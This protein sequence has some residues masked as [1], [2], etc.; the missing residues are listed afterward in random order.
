MRTLL[1][2]FALAAAALAGGCAH[3]PRPADADAALFHDAAFGRPTERVSTDDVFALDDAMRHYLRVEIAGALHA[4]GVQTGFVE[5]LSRKQ[6]LRLEYDSARTKTAAEAFDSRS[7]NCLSLVLMTAALAKELGLPFHYG[8]AV[9]PDLWSR[10][11]DLLFASGHINITIGRRLVDARSRFDLAPLT[12]DFLPPEEVRRLYTREI[13][14][15]TVLAMYANNR[16]AEALAGQRLADAY[17]WAREALRHDAA[18]ASAWNTLG[19]AYL[20]RGEAGHAT[21]VFEHV[22]STLD[23]RDTSTLSNLATAYARLGRNADA[24]TA[25]TRLAAIEAEPPY[26]FFQL[27]MHALQAGDAATASAHFEREVSRADYQPE[28]HHWLGVARWRLGDMAGARRELALAV[29][30]SS[31]RREHDLYS[32]KLA[33]LARAGIA[34][35]NPR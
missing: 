13:E 21:A 2:T 19:V 4:Q 30:N 18:F 29:S 32:A 22:L 25:R 17:A 3:T 28:F 6:G 7:G 20:R 10:H 1:V 33:W 27:G 9:M 8:R 24:E 16:A 35:P 5:A 34:S 26:H 15:G 11:D 23:A 12:I 31:S 14:E